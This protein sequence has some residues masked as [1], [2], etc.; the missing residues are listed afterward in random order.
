[1][2]KTRRALALPIL[3]LAAVALS[4]GGC[5]KVPNEPGSTTAAAGSEASADTLTTVLAD[6]SS[7]SGTKALFAS[8]DLAA[9][10]D[11]RG[12]YTVFAPSNAALDGVPDDVL[13]TLKS[14]EAKPQ[15]TSLL[16]GHIV[17]G[18]VTTADIA[19]AIEAG[20]GS[21]EL[22]TMAGDVLTFA[23]QGDA[24]TVTAPGGASATI[25]SASHQASNGV[26]HVIDGVLI[27]S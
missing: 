23:K 4:L 18:T 8:A 17:P 20:G 1:M 19:K 3:G 10:L 16:T 12:P 24:I 21:A 9:T 14:A 2:T 7:L 15:L 26:V 13:A 6:D 11:G 25:G 22:K 27:R 5:K